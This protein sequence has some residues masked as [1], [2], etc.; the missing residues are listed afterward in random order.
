MYLEY[1][2]GPKKATKKSEGA[3]GEMGYCVK[4]KEKRT[5]KN[6]KKVQTKNGRNALSG[7]CAK[8]GTKM[9]KFVK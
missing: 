9:M 2:M 6:T 1:I 8:C 3:S 5:M 7:V 4:C